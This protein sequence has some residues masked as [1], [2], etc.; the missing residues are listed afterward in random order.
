MRFLPNRSIKYILFLSVIFFVFPLI[1]KAGFGLS[2]GYIKIDNALRGSSFEKVFVI[3]RSNPVGNLI[4]T[5]EPLGDT[6]EWFQFDRGNKFTYPEGEKQFPIKSIVT[7][8]GGT[9][10]GTYTGKIRFSG[11]ADAAD[12]KEGASVSITM[13]ALADISITVTD[14]EMKGFRLIGLQA[15]KAVQGESLVLSLILENTG[16]VDIQP[17]YIIAEI[18]DKFYKLQLATFRVSKFNGSVKVASSGKVLATVPWTIPDAGNYWAEISV[19]G[20]KNQ[21][22]AKE[23]LPFDASPGTGLLATVDKGSIMYFVLGGIII[24]LVIVIIVFVILLI[25]IRNK[26]TKELAEMTKHLMKLVKNKNGKKE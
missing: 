21:L 18:F 3:S 6:A 25:N 24:F 5:V 14:K 10:N 13:G 4:V 11:S 17:S 1:T 22:V 26:Q 23:K 12:N 9:P 8:P 19:F 7:I 20:D 16:N 15:E 2:P